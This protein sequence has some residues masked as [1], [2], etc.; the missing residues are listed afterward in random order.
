M[1]GRSALTE[2]RGMIAGLKNTSGSHVLTSHQVASIVKA[3]PKD[4]S[5][6][7]GLRIPGVSSNKL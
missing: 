5:S 3:W 6:L 1:L 4:E 2:L 7:L